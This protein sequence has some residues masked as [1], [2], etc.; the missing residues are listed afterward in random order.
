MKFRLEN[1]THIF[2]YFFP[3]LMLTACSPEKRSLTIATAA[4]MQFAMN[5]LVEAYEAETG[6]QCEIILGS[7]GKLTAQIQEGAPYDLFF[8]ADMK[9]P[10]ALKA[11]GNTIGE[12]IIYA[13]GQLVLWTSR[14]SPLHRVIEITRKETNHIALANP[15]T[16]PYGEAA[17]QVLRNLDLYDMVNSK[18]V[19]GESISQV[20]QFV[21]SGAAEYGFTAKPVVLSPNMSSKGNW[22]T[23]PDSLHAPIN[24]A[25]VIL[26]NERSMTDEAQRFMEFVLSEKGKALLQKF[27]YKT[28]PSKPFP[29]EER[30]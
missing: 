26:R 25:M 9:F 12:P 22:I 11:T 15:K 13:Q 20:N 23:I 10:E 8:S 6:T 4:N 24:Q 14:K 19:Y 3:V 28:P 17:I 7:S 5:A 21:I 1:T 27:G 2:L 30:L 16:A 29:T 18:L